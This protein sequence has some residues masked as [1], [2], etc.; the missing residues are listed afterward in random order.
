M[1]G[2]LDFLRERRGLSRLA[3]VP[4]L[5]VR[6]G[7]LSSLGR[8]ITDP[9]TGQPFFGNAIPPE[10]ISPI[11]LKILDLFPPPNLPGSSGNYLNNAVLRNDVTQAQVRLD[12]RVTGG[13][14]LTARYNYGLTDAYEP[15]AEDTESVPG[16]G[17]YLKDGAQNLMLQYQRTLALEP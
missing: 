10:R 7:D 5:A 13:D 2:T 4:T 1:F 3:T 8:T 17:D 6:G 11:A 16:F 15:Y 12:H 14:L 9:Y